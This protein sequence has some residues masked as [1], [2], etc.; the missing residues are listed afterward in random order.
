VD[1]GWNKVVM[2]AITKL[3]PESQGSL[4]SAHVWHYL[5][6]HGQFPP[7]QGMHTVLTWLQE[8]R[9]IQGVAGIA[10]QSVAQ[11]GALLITWVSPKLT[12]RA[13]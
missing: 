4:S 3:W 5:T 11:H 6:S 12:K 7:P 1:T 10:P 9:L 2:Q 8:Q 13:A